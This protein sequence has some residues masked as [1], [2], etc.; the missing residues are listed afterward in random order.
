MA[1]KLL[2]V[3]DV[4]GSPASDTVTFKTSSGNHQKDYCV[5]HLQ[6]L[7]QGSRTP[8][9]GRRPGVVAQAASTTGVKKTRAQG[10]RTS[11]KT[12]VRKA[13]AGRQRAAA[14]PGFSKN[15]KRLGRPPGS[16]GKKATAKKA[17][18]KRKS[19]ASA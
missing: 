11:K 8:R 5:T 9:R 3:C 13:T 10:S 18:A 1:E 19:K 2:L 14:R 16:S 4:C 12:S 7:L 15:G 6:A 17:A